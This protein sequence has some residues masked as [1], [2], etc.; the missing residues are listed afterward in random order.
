ML[1]TLY[2][3]QFASAD[4]SSAHENL[5]KGLKFRLGKQFDEI[6]VFGLVAAAV[7]YIAAASCWLIL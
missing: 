1:S 3:E 7:F 2:R 4:G 5:S 6:V